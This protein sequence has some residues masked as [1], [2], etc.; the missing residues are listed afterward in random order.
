MNAAANN[1]CPPFQYAWHV[2]TIEAGVEYWANTMGVGP[3]FV[4]DVDAADR[5]G[6]TY[7]GAP[8][9]LTMRVA[10]AET[11]AGQIE[12]IQVTS[13]APNVY[14][15]LIAPDQTAFH[16][17]GVWSDDYAADKTRLS[18]GYEVAMDMGPDTNICYVDTSAE[19]GT[20]LELIERNDSI[21]GLFAL[22]RK[23]A[24]TWD[25]SR[26]LRDMADLFA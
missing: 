7:R 23:A 6:V 10:W 2:P 14:H 18:S 13:S 25:G 21:V 4:S 9:E 26:P 5:N 11:A 20:M 8:A 19:S 1:P 12:L 3:F 24:D 15:D 16:H 17:V 22:I